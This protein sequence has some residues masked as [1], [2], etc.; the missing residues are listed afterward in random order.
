MY[1]YSP[2]TCPEENRLINVSLDKQDLR[3]SLPKENLTIHFVH[4][5]YLLPPL[6]IAL[7]DD[8]LLVLTCSKRV[9]PIY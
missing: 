1:P 6:D 2:T 5:T 9:L 7:F 4:Y 8:L 3:L